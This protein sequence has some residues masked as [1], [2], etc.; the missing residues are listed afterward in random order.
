MTSGEPKSSLYGFKHLKI[1][2]TGLAI[3]GVATGSF[4]RWQHSSSRIESLALHQMEVGDPKGAY[5][6]LSALQ[7]K[8]PLPEFL[9]YQAYALRQSDL[10]NRSNQRLVQAIQLLESEPQPLKKA[11]RNLLLEMRLNQALNGHLSNDDSLFKEGLDQACKLQENSPWVFLLQSLQYQKKRDFTKASELAQKAAK[12]TYLSP[13]MKVSFSTT[14]GKYWVEL[15]RIRALIEEGK[16]V[17]ARELIS[18]IPPKDPSCR[19]QVRLLNSLNHIKEAQKKPFD[20]SLAYFQLS[21]SLI[22]NLPLHSPE[23]EEV[24]NEIAQAFEEQGQKALSAEAMKDLSFYVQTLSSW[25]DHKHLEP[26][27]TNYIQWLCDKEMSDEMPSIP[28][29]DDPQLKMF[30]SSA[31]WH[32]IFYNTLSVR[33]QKAIEEKRWDLIGRFWS[34]TSTSAQTSP[35]LVKTVTSVIEQE[36]EKRFQRLLKE[37][38]QS[39]DSQILEPAFAD[40]QQLLPLLAQIESDDAKYQIFLQKLTDEATVLI[41]TPKISPASD[42]VFGMLIHSTNAPQ[43][44]RIRLMLKDRITKRFWQARNVQ[45]TSAMAALFDIC[46]KINIDAIPVYSPDA[47]ANMV[48]DSKFMLDN[49]KVKAAQDQ[50]RW[51]L[52]LEPQNEQARVI[53]GYS[54]F[55]SGEFAKAAH[56]FEQIKSPTRQ[57]RQLLAIS[58]LRSN[59]KVKALE[60]INKIQARGEILSDR[61]SFETALLKANESEWKESL[62]FLQNIRQKN[63]DVWIYILAAEYKLSSAKGVWQAYNQLPVLMRANRALTALALKSAEKIE[64]WALADTILEKAMSVE[65]GQAIISQSAN[66]FLKKHFEE[67]EIDIDLVASQYFQE[68]KQNP[69]KAL[70]ILQGKDKANWHVLAER[71]RA[72]IQ[73]GS[74][75]EAYEELIRSPAD[76]PMDE[77]HLSYWLLK[78]QALRLQGRFNESL[79]LLSLLESQNKYPSRDVTFEKANLMIEG[80]RLDIAVKLLESVVIAQSSFDDI[81]LLASSL[82]QQGDFEKGLKWIEIASRK[83]MSAWAAWRLATILWPAEANRGS[84][85]QI[86]SKNL[87]EVLTSEQKSIILQKM[88]DSGFSTQAQSWGK[89]YA[90][91]LGEG[92]ESSMAR[93]QLHL[94]EK[95]MKQAHLILEQLADNPHLSLN[96]LTR[97]LDWLEILEEESLLKKI[98]SRFSLPTKMTA[99]I[100]QSDRY[101][102]FLTYLSLA[103][104]SQNKQGI[105]DPNLTAQVNAI[106]HSTEESRRNDGP[107]YDFWIHAQAS[108]LLSDNAKADKDLQLCQT[109]CSSFIKPYVEVSKILKQSSSMSLGADPLNQALKLNPSHP[110]IELYLAEM[111]FD[112]A[113]KAFQTDDLDLIQKSKQTLQFCL[114]QAPYLVRAH[115]LAARMAV[116]EKNWVLAYDELM[117]ANELQP[118]NRD[119]LRFIESVLT[120]RIENEGSRVDWSQQL[121]DIRRQLSSR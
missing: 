113:Q 1:A 109:S 79:S 103:K 35:E 61:L 82:I 116:Y 118:G 46:A 43:P 12:R 99:S 73:M 107:L 36:V 14:F 20:A 81:Y 108:L 86:P 39:D 96:Q 5:E 71:A 105:L 70:E 21:Y 68:S 110:W 63:A 33:V 93:M 26:L 72:L 7:D 53:L 87:F 74:Y 119:I 49:N 6:K 8:I 92:F 91:D 102:S 41:Q 30:V 17:S 45:D 112:I 83:D 57:L 97:L 15:V 78:S 51:V 28:S 16:T 25:R 60:A 50:L 52:K 47:I 95:Q 88:M 98:A 31:E 77:E 120:Q 54:Y 66:E 9:L 23:F 11:Q 89:I 121:N 75:Q 56:I 94:L 85:I 24:Y 115:F 4:I 44:E 84:N 37:V 58:Y 3:A 62:Q 117:I 2:L 59:Q 48:A 42:E 114:D 64:L 65:P 18:Q 22:K 34:I 90:N 55:N 111:Q 32:D 29:Q 40:L 104:V 76:L 67:H 19:D 10:I 13:W 69:K 100:T 38:A 80:K 27:A 101:C 106:A